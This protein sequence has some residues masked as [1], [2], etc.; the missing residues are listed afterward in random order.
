MLHTQ[1]YIQKDVLLQCYIYIHTYIYI[2]FSI[3]IYMHTYTCIHVHFGKSDTDE[4]RPSLLVLSS[5]QHTAT[6]YNTL[7]QT[8]IR[9]NTLQHSAT[10]TPAHAITQTH[11]TMRRGQ[12]Q[13]SSKHAYI[14]TSLNLVC[15]RDPTTQGDLASFVCE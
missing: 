5:L 7:Q 8:V 4:Y 10:H 3:Y 6:H 13:N 11:L 14:F 1:T 15:K 9:C 2:C 12:P